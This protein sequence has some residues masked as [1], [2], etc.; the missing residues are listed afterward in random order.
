[1]INAEYFQNDKLPASQRAGRDWIGHADNRPW[2]YSLAAPVGDGRLT[3][4]RAPT[5]PTGSVPHHLFPRPW[6]MAQARASVH[7]RPTPPWPPGDGRDFVKTNNWVVFGHHFA[8]IAGPGPLVGPVLAAQFGYLPGMLWMLVGA[9]LG[10]AVH[11]SVILCCPTRRRGKSLGQMVRD[12]A[13]PF[14]GGVALVS[15]V[16]I[17]TIL[18]AVLALVVVKALAESSWGLFTIAATM[19]IALVMG[20]AMKGAGHSVK[21]LVWISAFGELVPLERALAGLEAAPDGGTDAC[22]PGSKTY[23]V[24]EDGDVSLHCRIAP[25]D[26]AGAPRVLRVVVRWSHAEFIG[27]EWLRE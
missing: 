1:V 10:G 2:G 8:A 4:S 21:A 6:L 3:D 25:A 16:A 23:F 12:E 24:G 15:I 19:P 26:R 13:G 7:P 18:L 22:G 20:F 27:F 9:T 17:M 11:D 14:A 5:A